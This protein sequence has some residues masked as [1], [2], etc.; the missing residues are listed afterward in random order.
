MIICH[1]SSECHY[2]GLGNTVSSHLPTKSWKWDHSRYGC[3]VD[4]LNEILVFCENLFFIL[5]TELLIV[6][7]I[8]KLMPFFHKQVNLWNILAAFY[9]SP[10]G[11]LLTYS[12]YK[13]L[14]YH[15]I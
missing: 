1:G 5:F 9:M 13:F 4:D 10:F 2:S 14:L 3:R 11:D 15:V 7:S 12:A 8:F 6:P